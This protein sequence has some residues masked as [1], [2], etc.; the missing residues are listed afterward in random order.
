MSFEDQD[1]LIQAENRL[2]KMVYAT[3]DKMDRNA[4][5]RLAQERRRVSK[6]KSEDQDDFSDYD[7]LASAIKNKNDIG[8][9]KNKLFFCP[10]SFHV[11]VSFDDGHIADFLL[12]RCKSLNSLIEID[13]K[14]SFMSTT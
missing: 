13:R 1:K 10:Y 2:I 7:G 14:P 3:L 12:S 5:G 6:Y 8:K 9:L 11:K 4:T